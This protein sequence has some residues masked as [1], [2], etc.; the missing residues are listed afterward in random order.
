MVENTTRQPRPLGRSPLIL[1]TLV[2]AISSGAYW[3]WKSGTVNSLAS[4]SGN[5]K[6]TQTAGETDVAAPLEDDKIEP[7]SLAAELEASVKKLASDIG[8]RNL[9]HHAA[10][11]RAA[12]WIESELESF[13]YT[14]SRQTFE[15][16]GLECHNLIVEI[17]GSTQ[18]TEI[19]IIGAHYDSAPGTPGANDNGS[20]TAATLALAARFA[21]SK[22]ARTLRF[23]FFTN[24]E[25][26]YFQQE[27]QMGSLVYAR[28]CRQK[29]EDIR[30]VISLETIGYYS[31]EPNSQHYPPPLNL[32][33]PST[34]NF[35]GFVS[36][37]DSR[38]LLTQVVKTFRKSS[39]FPSEFA[40]LPASV[41]GVGWSDH[42]SFWQVG[43][44]GIMI[45]D[46]APFRYPHYHRNTDTPDKI[47]FGRMATVVEGLVPV[48]EDLVAEQQ[49]VKK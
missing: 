8:E 5:K 4:P 1:L 46:T 19:V 41:E 16:N 14:V 18:P 20:G 23:V 32:L 43:Y 28:Q 2:I 44:P 11:N 29:N 21:T 17:V 49:P 30:A 15:V 48:I 37:L 10:L 22:P 36:D 33:Y 42:W 27:N 12:D 35:I 47:D 6:A 13:E 34:G 7:I 26:P 31:D 38:E 39:D 3:L 40:T 25:P 45:T 9:R 24:E